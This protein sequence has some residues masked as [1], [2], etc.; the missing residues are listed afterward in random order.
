M[1]ITTSGSTITFSDATTQNSAGTIIPSGTAM[2]FQ[3]TAAPTGWTKSTTY[4]DYAIRIVSGTASTGGSSNFST[5]FANQ[6]P[7]ISTGG[8]SAGA[9]T[10]STAQ[11]P[12]HSHQQVVSEGNNSCPGT[13]NPTGCVYA[14]SPGGTDFYT[15]NTGSGGSHSHSISGSATSS[16]VTLAVKYV[17]HIIATKN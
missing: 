10:L 16:A 12:A 5:C 1:T 14:A 8:L 9:T 15:G 3:Q 13:R 2:L 6:T 17:D 4:N 7:T 11:I